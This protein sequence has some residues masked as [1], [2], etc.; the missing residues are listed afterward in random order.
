MYFCY[1]AS[2]AWT[3]AIILPMIIGH[4]IPEE[5]PH[6]ECYL[7]L[8]QIIQY[9]LAKVSSI[10]SSCYLAALIDQHHQ[11]FLQCYP[12]VR[13]LPKMHYMVHFSQQILRLVISY[14]PWMYLI[15]FTNICIGWVHWS[16]L[17]ACAWKQRIHILKVQQRYLTSRMYLFL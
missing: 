17:G 4:K 11:I 8:L 3:F 10:P 9:S 12:G 16:H 14:L 1:I 15:K 5:D 6:W 7:L 13:I 2:Q